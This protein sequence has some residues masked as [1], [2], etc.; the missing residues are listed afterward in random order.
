M[1]EFFRKIANVEVRNILA[2]I[3]TIGT[4]AVLYLLIIKPV[5]VENKDILYASV[6]FIFGG[7]LSAVFGFYYGASK[8]NNVKEDET[9]PKV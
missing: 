8:V 7:A 2:V 5:P 1:T 3:T 6:G 9:K 4:F